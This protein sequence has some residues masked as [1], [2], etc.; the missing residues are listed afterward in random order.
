MSGTETGAARWYAILRI[1][2]VYIVSAG[3][4]VAPDFSAKDYIQVTPDFGLVS[5]LFWFRF[6]LVSVYKKKH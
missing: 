5:V 3:I 1:E 2:S 6:G 4:Q